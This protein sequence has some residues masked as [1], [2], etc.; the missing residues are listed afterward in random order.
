MLK[1]SVVHGSTFERSGIV[2]IKI[3]GNLIIINI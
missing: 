2:K 3:I 1:D